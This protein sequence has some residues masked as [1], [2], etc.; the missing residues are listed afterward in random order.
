MILRTA[1][2][3]LAWPIL[4]LRPVSTRP[5]FVVG[6]DR[7][8]TTWLGRTLGC[9]AAT[10]YIHEPLNPGASRLG[11]WSHWN[12]YL[13]ATDPGGELAAIF[14]R[15]TR[16]LPKAPWTRAELRKRLAPGVRL[17]IKETG[18]MLCGAWFAQRYA[19]EVVAI[20]RH[21]V[22]VVLSNLKQDVRPEIWREQL[23]SQAAL[24]ED[25]LAPYREQLA[26]DGSAVEVMA[27]V[28]AARHR[29]LAN[30][31]AKQ[32]DWHLIAYEA[33]CGDPLAGYRALFERL[34]LVLD[35]SGEASIQASTK[36]QDDDF[37]G[38]RRVSAEM[39]ERW[40]SE[41]P[42]EDVNRIREAIQPFGLPFYSKAE[43][44]LP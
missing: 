44:W 14:D 16:G 10:L 40:K 25:H 27:R 5:I 19:A 20:V 26:R 31:L 13:R 37:F 43:D 6:H 29:V 39:P 17:V 18:G 42:R 32:K 33:L 23:L 7:S 35:K 11:H 2:N 41:A 8:G 34:G 22:P 24:M 38:T 28:W 30:Q 9:S 3:L 12:S 21:P 36:S 15:I 1:M 4:R